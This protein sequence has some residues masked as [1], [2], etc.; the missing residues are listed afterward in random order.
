M[1]IDILTQVCVLFILI[2]LGVLLAKIK[3]LG[4]TTI[5][6]MTDFVLTIVSPCV[7]IKSFVREFDPALTKKLL[8]SFFISIVVHIGYILICHLFIHDND[9]GKEKVMRF[10]AIFSNCGF[11]S[12]PL[13]E[14]ILG[15]DGVFYGTSYLAIFYVIVWSYGVFLMSG[16]REDLSLKKIVINPGI[17]GI[18]LG[19]SIFFLNIPIHKAPIISEP[20][21]FLAGLNTPLPMIIIGYHLANS[22]LLS[23][24]KSFKSIFSMGLKL[25]IFPLLTLIGMYLCG[26]RGE[27][28]V[29]ITISAS[30]PT[31]A[32]TTMFSSKYGADTTLSVSMVSLST[33]ISILSMPFIITLAQS[34]A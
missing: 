11:M 10:A 26:I 30:A 8:I 20:I 13:L 29:A 24:I 32:I 21:I 27:V 22:K 19:L 31:A 3:M 33:I 2:L 16:K 1:F 14:A 34:I 23:A 18:V 17:I 9:K 25:I 5:K 28:L 6:Q 15:D 7:I 12:I 4:E